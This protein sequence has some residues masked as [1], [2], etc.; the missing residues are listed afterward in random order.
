MSKP[1]VEIYTVGGKFIGSFNDEELDNALDQA[2]G[3][4]K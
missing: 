4:W 3:G 2:T 1:I